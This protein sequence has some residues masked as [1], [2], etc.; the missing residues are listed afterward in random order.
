MEV[1]E[2]IDRR[3]L[4]VEDTDG[5]PHAHI[6]DAEEDNRT[7]KGQNVG[8]FQLKELTEKV[9]EVI[10]SASAPQCNQQENDDGEPVAECQQA[11][12]SKSID[13]QRNLSILIFQMTK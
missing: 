11:K 9:V 6:L 5:K 3:A 8:S 13:G 10:Q 2:Q 12:P 7:E 1:G 4:V